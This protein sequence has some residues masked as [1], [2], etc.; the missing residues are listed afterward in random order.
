MRIE[1]ENEYSR[2]ESGYK[3]GKG[4]QQFHIK[5]ATTKILR[6]TLQNLDKQY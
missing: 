2:N 6:K 1:R 5:Q 4:K 3:R